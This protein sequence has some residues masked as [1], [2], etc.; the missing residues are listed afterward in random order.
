MSEQK[1]EFG[2]GVVVCLAKFSEHLWTRTE[3]AIGELEGLRKGTRQLG[4]LSA[5]AKS[6]LDFQEHWWNEHP[7]YR[8]ADTPLEA[9]IDE[10]ID[11][12]AN[13]AGDHF[14]DLDEARAPEPLKKLGALMLDLRT[15]HFREN[16]IVLT[17]DVMKEIRELWE[18]SCIALDEKLGTKP[19]W[20]EW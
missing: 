12:W 19:D 16:N 6:K 11:M 3:S 15:R 14:F 4:E 7:E 18:Q 17:A 9:A 20:G 13:G 2:A 1:S 5:E 8:R 10:A